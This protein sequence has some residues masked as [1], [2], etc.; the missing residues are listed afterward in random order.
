MPK[1]ALTKEEIALLKG[2]ARRGDVDSGF[3]ELLQTLC[4]LLD[5][6]TGE[7]FISQHTMA[8]V[9]LYGT[10]SGHPTWRGLLRCIF[11]RTLGDDLGR[12]RESS[13]RLIQKAKAAD[14]QTDRRVP[15]ASRPKT[16]GR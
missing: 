9:Q 7:I 11:Q 8:I 16:Q 15:P 4:N 14:K 13:G 3:Q 5:S 12:R 2:A 1:I 6:E 10:G